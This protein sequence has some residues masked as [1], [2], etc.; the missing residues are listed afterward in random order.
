VIVRPVGDQAELVMQVE[1]SE[2]AGDLADAWGAPGVP[3]LDPADRVRTAARMHDV[4]W[5][6]W[7]SAPALHPSTGRPENFLDVD[8]S[9]HLGFY[10]AAVD[11]VAA[12]DPYA[13][14][15]VSK[16]AAGIY[17]GRYGTQPAMII[18]RAADQQA[19][20][21]A[22][23]ARQEAFYGGL[24]GELGVD[25]DELWRNYVLLQVFDRLS[26]WLCKGDPAGTGRMEIALPDRDQP[27]VI[28]PTDDGAALDPYPFA[29][30]GEL[31]VRVPVRTVPLNGYADDAELQTRIAAAPVEWRE[32]RLVPA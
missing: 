9:R 3:A 27:L 20:V 16:H 8:V 29:D 6:S 10:Q 11:E 5:R 15:L 4:G 32:S 25:E 31:V 23:V 13:G 1:H 2:V 24:A 26:L 21:D 22:F 14:M 19:E 12:A 28:E 7:E 30:G 17:T 18:S